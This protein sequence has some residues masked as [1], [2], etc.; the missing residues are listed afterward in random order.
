MRASVSNTEGKIRSLCKAQG[1]D[2][3][4]GIDWEGKADIEVWENGVRVLWE[5]FWFE[6]GVDIYTD[7]SALD[8]KHGELARGAGA[9]VQRIKNAGWRRFVVMAPKGFLKGAAVPEQMAASIALNRCGDRTV[10][11]AGLAL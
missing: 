1:F 11:G 4:E 8:T 9:A 7:G 10:E 5:S 6:E 2:R 3:E